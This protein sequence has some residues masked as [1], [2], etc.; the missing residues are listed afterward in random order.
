MS[1]ENNSDKIAFSTLFLPDKVFLDKYIGSMSVTA[2][3]VANNG[4]VTTKTI[5]Q[6]H[7]ANVFPVMLYSIDG[8]NWYDGGQSI[9]TG[10][11]VTLGASAYVTS[12]SIVVMVNNFT[13]SS[14][15]LN[16]KIALISDD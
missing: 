16:Y 10:I 5:P 4:R 8:N 12:T 3:T 15:T 13:T 7:G 6:P 1:I 14:Y 11:S 2:S 9:Q